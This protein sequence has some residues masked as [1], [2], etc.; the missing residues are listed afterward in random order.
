MFR[1][2]RLHKILLWISGINLIPFILNLF[3][4]SV[5]ISYIFN[6]LLIFSLL[7][8][9]FVLTFDL[10]D[11]ITYSL[12]LKKYQKIANKLI[13]AI[14]SEN[15]NEEEKLKKELETLYKKMTEEKKK[16]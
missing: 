12:R 10:I 11:L 9:S 14:Q 15:E 13:N 4:N 8:F 6:Y 2:K 16:F 3:L 1:T 7:L 5:Y